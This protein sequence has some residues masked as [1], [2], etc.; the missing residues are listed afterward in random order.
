[1]SVKRRNGCASGGSKK[2]L[3]IIRSWWWNGVG[4]VKGDGV[5][6][7]NEINFGCSIGGLRRE[8]G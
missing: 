2:I 1:V 5:S 7:R 6:I 3:R 8:I 4:G